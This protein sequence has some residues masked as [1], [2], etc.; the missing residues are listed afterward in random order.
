MQDA[1]RNNKTTLT[2]PKVI[3]G[4]AP[5]RFGSKNYTGLEWLEVGSLR[6]P[7]DDEVTA[8]VPY[9]GPRGSF[10]YVSLA[11]IWADRCRLKAEGQDRLDRRLRARPVRSSRNPGWDK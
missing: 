1:A 10:P 8:L 2:L 11:D 9:R 5:E 3:P 7:V 6:I 4:I